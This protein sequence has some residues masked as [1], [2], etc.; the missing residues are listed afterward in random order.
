M[1]ASMLSAHSVLPAR[2]RLRLAATISFALL[3]SA[4]G[5]GNAPPNA[6]APA[7]KPAASTPTLAPAAL[8]A[9]PAPSSTVAAAE[10]AAQAAQ[11]KLETMSV[12]QLLAEARTAFSQQRLVAP[13][14]NNAFEYYEKALQK[15]PKNQVAQD[16]LREAFPVGANTVEQTIGQNDYDEAQREIDLL[17]KADPSNYTL[18]ILRSKL[19]VARKQQ[20]RV[21]ALKAKQA[22]DLAAKQAEIAK[23]AAAAAA[24]AAAPA[25]VLAPV[26]KQPVAEEPKPVPVQAAPA[27]K[28]TPPP[29]PVGETRGAKPIS[30]AAPNYPLEAARNQTSGYAMVEFTVNTDGSVSGAHVLDSQPSRVFNSAAIEAVSRSK[31][32]PALKDGQ[33]VS[34]TLQRRVDFKFGG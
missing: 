5:G 20:Q 19:D 18:T 4:C 32:Q 34:S 10:Q 27:S 1:S 8:P 6:N 13:K 7:P 17:A 22:A 31:Y 23:A 2:A 15:D 26:V 3:L 16:A 29:Q 28:P 9:T 30:Q 24:K 25:P 11:A 14:G 33:P 12:K 21:E